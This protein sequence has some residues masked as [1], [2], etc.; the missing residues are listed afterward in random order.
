MKLFHLL[1]LAF[2]LPSFGQT[3]YDFPLSVS[4]NGRYLVDQSGTPFF[5]QA[6]TPWFLFYKLTLPEVEEYVDQR[7][8]Q[9]FNALQIM[10][11]GGRG[12]R[13]I[14]GVGPFLGD[15]DITRPDE[16]HFARVD[17]IL[18][19]LERKNMLVALVPL[20]AGCCRADYAG[21]DPDG[22]PLPL[23]R[24]GVD[25][26]RTYAR[27]LADRY[28][29]RDNLMW[30]VGG[31]NDPWGAHDEY[32]ALAEVL[33]DRCPKT[34]MTYHAASTHSSTDVFPEADWLDVSMVY[35]YFRGFNKAW[36]RIQ[37]DAYEVSRTERRK[38]PARP[39]FLGESTY[40]GEH[41]PWGSAEQVRKQAYYAVLS[42]AAGHAYGSDN[43]HLPDN[44]REVLQYPGAF[45]ME[46]LRRRMEERRWYEY[47]P[48]PDH[49][50]LTQGA[51]DFASNDY[52][53]VAVHPNGRAAM[54]Y[55]PSPRTLEIDLRSLARGARTITIVEPESG[56][57]K[58][59]PMG[60]QN[61]LEIPAENYPTFS[62]VL[63]F[64]DVE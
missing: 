21:E 13:N 16:R 23:N 41:L 15:D 10:L 11:T 4:D 34:L 55:V 24:A 36:N 20:W 37:P 56:L 2:T 32:A 60:E 14:H 63:I 45:S 58:R 49:R 1:L 31:D 44:W 64:V 19:I 50:V 29:G 54:I 59:V 22:N 52:A 38:S 6:D 30:I 25:G 51:G 18:N 61:V 12:L 3:T 48:D 42:G 57:K 43:W 8:A 62:D 27:Y 47:V 53:I 40:E 17:S 46:P 9:G 39:F 26:A 7:K 35:T 5:Y 33:D 28:C